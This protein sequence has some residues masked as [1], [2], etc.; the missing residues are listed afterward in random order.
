V[1][2]LVTV[3]SFAKRNNLMR[4]ERVEDRRDGF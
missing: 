2:L 4:F 1:A 3:K